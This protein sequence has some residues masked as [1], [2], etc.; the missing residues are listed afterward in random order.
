MRLRGTSPGISWLEYAIY[1]GT[2]IVCKPDPARF[3]WAE[4]VTCRKSMFDGNVE[5][6]RV[7]C[8]PLKP[9]SLSFAPLAL[10]STNFF[11]DIAPVL[12]FPNQMLSTPA[13]SLVIVYDGNPAVCIYPS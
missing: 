9:G 6:E 1:A 8:Q 10:A 5:G 13:V 4:R 7:I 3:T 11:P 12:K 2:D